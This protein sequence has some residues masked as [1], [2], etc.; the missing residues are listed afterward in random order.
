VAVGLL[1]GG[2]LDI[3]GKKWISFIIPETEFPCETCDVK[4]KDTPIVNGETVTPHLLRR[5]VNTECILA[6]KQTNIKEIVE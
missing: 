3:V 6:M 5:D 1:E 2:L 4:K